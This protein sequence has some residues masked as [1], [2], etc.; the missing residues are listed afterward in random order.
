M[1]KKVSMP[2]RIAPLQRVVAE[3]I[4]D[5]AEQAALDKFRKLEKQKPGGL[6]AKMNRNDARAASRS[7]AKRREEKRGRDS[8]S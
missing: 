5:P 3:V 2:P 8:W 7:R 1:S 4:T 6:K